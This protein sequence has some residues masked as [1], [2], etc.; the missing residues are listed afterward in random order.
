MELKRTE[1]KPTEFCLSFQF[2]RFDKSLSYTDS[3]CLPAHL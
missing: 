2:R 1:T 3:V